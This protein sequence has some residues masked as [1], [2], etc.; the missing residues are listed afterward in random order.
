MFKITTK[1]FMQPAKE[2]HVSNGADLRD[3]LLAIMAKAVGAGRTFVYIP[4]SGNMR[5]AIIFS[6]SERVDVE[7]IH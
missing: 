5:E 7:Q 1:R 4:A 6:D 2:L 3:A